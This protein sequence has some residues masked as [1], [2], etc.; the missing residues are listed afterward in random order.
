[1]IGSEQRRMISPPVF[2]EPVNATL[3]TP[4]C[5]TRYAPVVGPSPGTTLTTPA[6]KPTSAASS[7]S[8]SAVAGVC[9]SGLSDDG[10]AR[11]E[12]RGELPRRHHA[13]GSS[14]ARSARRRRPAPSA[15]RR[16]ASRRSASTGPRS[17]RSPR[18]RSGSSRSRTA[19]SAFT[20]AIA[21]PTLRVSSS[22]SSLRFALIASASACRRRERSFAGRLAPVPVER[23]ACGGD[24]AVDLRLAGELRAAERLAGR[25]LDELARLRALDGLAVDEEPELASRRDRHRGGC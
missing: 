7:A 15:C 3:S 24:G 6:G 18:R 19:I 2:V 8:R 23:G 21:L 13:A 10:A 20:D 22:A 5:R 9:A 4:G 16:G 11:G 25:G 17:S 12:R 1:M 14:T